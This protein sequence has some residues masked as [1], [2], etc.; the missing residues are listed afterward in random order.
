MD[1]LAVCL[2]GRGLSVL[3]HGAALRGV[4]GDMSSLPERFEA[5]SEPSISE[6]AFTISL[7]CFGCGQTGFAR[8]ERNLGCPGQGF[9]ASSPIQASDGFYLRVNVTRNFTMQVVC[10][11]C[12]KVQRGVLR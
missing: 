10:E 12:G 9:T 6:S 5:R 1:V 11:K 3:D 4:D 2:G 8:Y 7:C